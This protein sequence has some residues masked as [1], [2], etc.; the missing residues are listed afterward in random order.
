MNEGISNKL[1]HFWHVVSNVRP[2]VWI[3]LYLCLMPL[4]ALVYYWMPD[5]QFRI[6]D[7][8]GTDYGSWLYYSIVTITTLGF[9][10]Y[11]PAHGW[12]QA[13]TAIEVMCGLVFLGFFLNSVGSMKSEIDVETEIEKQHR[14]HQ[15]TEYD[16]LMKNIPVLLH[17]LNLYL[18]FCYAVTTPVGKRGA[19]GQFNQDFRFN[20]MHDLYLPSGLPTDYSSRPAVEGL[21]VCASNTSLYLDSLQSHVDLTLWPE[22]LEDSFAFVAACQMFVSADLLKDWPEKEVKENSAATVEEA[23]KKISDDIEAWSGP[24]ES[25]KRLDMAPAVELYHFIKETGKL[26]RNLELAA[27]KIASSPIH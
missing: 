25:G 16:K 13:V 9:G 18:S 10:D 22:M 7:N 15:A 12:A 11:T 19:A 23:I 14:V 24:E 17:R 26:A 21:M 8:A 3:C 1:K 2:I 27:T 20:D 6:P 4:F 5:G